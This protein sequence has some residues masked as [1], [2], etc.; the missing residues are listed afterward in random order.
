[1]KLLVITAVLLSSLVA[2]CSSWKTCGGKGVKIESFTLDGCSSASDVCQLKRSTN[3]TMSI[4]FT[5]QKDFKM[6][7]VT[8]SAKIATVVHR[9]FPGPKNNICDLR[10]VICPMKQHLQQTLSFNIYLSDDYPLL[11]INTMWNFKSSSGVKEGCFEETF[12]VVK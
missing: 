8:V 1:M 6:L 12:Q 10:N 5:P 2:N 3:L 4:T 9:D 7:N 11:R